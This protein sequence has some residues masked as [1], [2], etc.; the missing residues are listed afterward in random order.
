M[1]GNFNPWKKSPHEILTQNNLI[2]TFVTYNN[3]MLSTLSYITHE[4][5]E[6]QLSTELNVLEYSIA[7]DFDDKK[8]WPITAPK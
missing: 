7:Q 3:L 4:T 6:K 1:D 5:A 2:A 8:L